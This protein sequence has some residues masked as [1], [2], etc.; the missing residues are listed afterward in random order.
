MT[1]TR[2]GVLAGIAAMAA[3]PALGEAVT[4]SLRPMARRDGGSVLTAVATGSASGLV[5]AALLLSR[6][7]AS[8]GQGV[9]IQTMPVLL[10]A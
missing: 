3:G 2:R 9:V 7:A 10:T 1:V 6:V 4:R 5:G 8:E